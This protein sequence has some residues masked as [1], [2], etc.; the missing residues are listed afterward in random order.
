LETNTSGR[1]EGVKINLKQAQRNHKDLLKIMEQE[2]GMAVDEVIGEFSQI[3]NFIERSWKDLGESAAY[4]AID[5]DMIATLEAST[6]DQ[7][8]AFGDDATN[9]IADAMYAQ[10]V[11]GGRFSD[12]TTAVE[13]VLTGHVDARGRPMT[14]YTKQFSNDAV[15][16]FHNEVN[17]KKGEDLG[18]NQFLY[19]GDIMGKT[20]HF[21]RIRAMKTYTRNQ[22]DSWTHDWQGKA[23]PAFEYRGGYNCRHHWRPIRKE[24][25]EDEFGETTDDELFAQANQADYLTIDKTVKE[26]DALMAKHDASQAKSKKL[27]EE[28]KTASAARK[29]E[30][31]K[32]LKPLKDERRELK[33]QI[34][35]LKGN[36]GKQGKKLKSDIKQG[37]KPKPLTKKQLAKEPV[38]V[39]NQDLERIGINSITDSGS[40]SYRHFQEEIVTP[41]RVEQQRIADFGNGILRE[42]FEKN[43]ML[44]N[45]Y[46]DIDLFEILHKD[47]VL[48]SHNIHHVGGRIEIAITEGDLTAKGL[49][50]IRRGGYQVGSEG[51]SIYRHE[52]GHHIHKVILEDSR[53][54]RLWDDIYFNEGDDFWRGISQYAATN[55]KEGF[56]EAFTMYA[57][58][59]YKR[60]WL[61]LKVE[62]YFDDLFGMKK[63]P[64]NIPAPTLQTGP[65]KY[66][67]R[68]KKYGE[69]K[70]KKW[71]ATLDTAEI[72]SLAAYKADM[73]A[74]MVVN[75][76]LRRGASLR[77][78]RNIEPEYAEM[79]QDM[80]KALSRGVVPHDS[81]VWR[82]MGGTRRKQME[83][84]IGKVVTDKAYASTS[85]NPNVA[86]NFADEALDYV[87]TNTPMVARISVP[88]GTRG[89]YMGYRDIDID[90]FSEAELLLDRNQ[91]FKV[92]SIEK[93]KVP[94]SL[95]RH[96][97]FEEYWHVEME[98][99]P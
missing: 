81:Y 48:G 62:R 93:R 34:V 53:W 91:K 98:A 28:R 32:L 26:R 4:T 64:A 35:A 24:W 36:L 74:Y 96:V 29:K 46:N 73:D 80:D 66:A 50:T 25:L 58:P 11:S 30:I 47:G 21:C 7:F 23:G 16:N 84:T 45:T 41:L 99:I 70:W 18:M 63:T 33:E 52:V 82:G 9:Q 20:R 57:H 67:N 22:I 97:S 44:I 39:K 85:F 95:T 69:L 12:L 78:I 51:M 8:K 88:R 2:Y 38:K 5:K 72:E 3:S 94:R 79:I 71:H 42:G 77:T 90:Q 15:M 54:F 86:F 6:W 83:K 43:P 75:S 61:P 68:T 37:L 89:G 76:E 13:G 27:K 55:S 92:L 17:T 19:V 40:Q 87:D 56:A 49:D 59:Q 1:L 65:R 60:G 31:N 14:A 10:V